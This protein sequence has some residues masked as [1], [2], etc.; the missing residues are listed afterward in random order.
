MNRN[1]VFAAL[2]AF[3]TLGAGGNSDYADAVDRWAEE[4]IARVERQSGMNRA[5]IW[6]Q[7]CERQG[8]RIIAKQSDGGKWIVHCVRATGTRA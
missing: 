8:K 7:K 1:L 4:K 3:L 2:V 5:R 6:S